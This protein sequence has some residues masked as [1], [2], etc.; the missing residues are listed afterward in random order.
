MRYPISK[1]L[2]KHKHKNPISFHVPGHK[3]GLVTGTDI[4]SQENLLKYDITE[5]TDLDD[6]HAPTDAIKDSMKR[7][8]KIYSSLGSNYLVNGSTVGNLAMILATCKSGDR[9]II[10]RNAHKSVINAVELADAQP[11]FVQP[12]K[13]RKTGTYVGISV[14]RI[15]EVRRMYDVSVC[16]L[17]YPSYYGQV[18]DIKA[19]IDYC[20]EHNII[21]L[22]DEAHGA[23]L[24]LDESF[25]SSALN[26]GADIVVQSA[27]KTLPSLTMTSWLHVGSTRVNKVE[28]ERYLSMLQSSSPSYIFLHSLENAMEFIYDFK[29]KKKCVENF[30]SGRQTFLKSLHHNTQLT[31]E[32]MDDPL[33]IYVKLRGYS[34]YQLQSELEELGIFSELADAKGVLWILPLQWSATYLEDS[35]EKLKLLIQNS[36]VMKSDEHRNIVSYPSVSTISY[37]YK[38]LRNLEVSVTTIDQAVGK[39]IAEPL[40]PYPPGIPLV[41]RGER[42]TED[43]ALEIQ[44]LLKNGLHIQGTTKLKQVRVFS[45]I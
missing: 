19:V 36:E 32:E 6:F 39:V 1:S 30:F 11:I 27:H 17:T 14:E 10:P 12:E 4:V 25:P 2:Q 22:V 42:L 20:H 38:E 37:T 16:V 3:Y 9:V 29:E 26:L 45:T 43:V 41:Q 7:L 40:I 15:K 44:S 28:L 21:V 13:D 34:G 33:K 18:Y 35:I 31:F 23:H 8:E 5:L 24:L